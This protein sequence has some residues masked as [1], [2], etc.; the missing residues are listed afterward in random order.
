MMTNH[1]KL[2]L[3]GLAALLA[4]AVVSSAHA[5]ELDQYRIGRA[6]RAAASPSAQA[7]AKRSSEVA[8]QQVDPEDLSIQAMK[9]LTLPSE[10]LTTGVLPTP[11]TVRSR[12]EEVRSPI[13]PLAYRLGLSI[14][15]YEP[16]GQMSVGTLAPY[17]ISVVGTQ[18]M[19]ALEGQWL[20]FNITSIPGLQAGLF[21][22]LGYAQHTVNLRSPTGATL[23]DTVLHSLKAQAGVTGSYQL[24]KSPRWSAH[25]NLGVGRL[26]T[27][28]ASTS[29][30]ANSS[31]SSWFAS[32]GLAAER[33]LIPNLSAYIGY[34]LRI[35]LASDGGGS[36]LP[37][38]NILI[39]FLGN[40]E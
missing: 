6:P 30:Y 26:S 16:K 33:N 38:H 15:P 7:K 25:G 22:S 4:T 29:S 24:P 20:P 28:Q 12:I 10:D 34:D 39:G 5:D 23:E 19:V 32:L 3:F 14:Q 8:P 9:E 11:A 31:S 2:S 13:R 21:A 36:D 40:F 27:I 17:D 37:A 1:F 18:P 35:R